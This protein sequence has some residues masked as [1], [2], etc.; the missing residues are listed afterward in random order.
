[1]TVFDWEPGVGE[2]HLEVATAFWVHDGACFTEEFDDERLDFFELAYFGE[3][4]LV[5]GFDNQPVAVFLEAQE[6]VAG[7]VVFDF[8]DDRL[9]DGVAALAFEAFDDVRCA[10]SGCGCVPEAQVRYFVSM[11]VFRALD[12]FG[13]G[14]YRVAC[15]FVGGG[16]N[17][18]HDF[19][20]A[21]YNNGAIRIHRRQI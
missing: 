5:V 17:L 4:V 11:Q 16:I 21:L 18:D 9:R 3:H 12:E 14:G 13:K 10:Q 19:E 8:R 6:A 1:M 7:H 15:C 20:V 2:G